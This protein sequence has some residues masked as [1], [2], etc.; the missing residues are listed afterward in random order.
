MRSKNSI[1]FDGPESTLRPD[2]SEGIE[3]SVS[4]HRITRDFPL[5]EQEV[6]I[7]RLNQWFNSGPWGKNRK[8][9]CKI[10]RFRIAFGA[11]QVEPLFG[12]TVAFTIT[13]P[14]VSVSDE[15]YVQHILRWS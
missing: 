9:S 12:N 15:A 14:S 11:P 7:A 1:L 2:S 13:M 8:V 6:N 3:Y 5:D 10:G 4:A